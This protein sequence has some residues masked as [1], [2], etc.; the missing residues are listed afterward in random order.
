MQV[1]RMMN[2]LMQININHAIIILLLILLQVKFVSV[3]ETELKKQG[4]KAT[5][6]FE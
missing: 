2:Q 1:F 3:D 4:K 5:P 6:N